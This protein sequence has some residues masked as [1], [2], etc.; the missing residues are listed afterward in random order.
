MSSPCPAIPAVWFNPDQEYITQKYFNEIAYR[1]R[2][3]YWNGGQN[4][5]LVIEDIR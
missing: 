3:N 5:Q 4:I 1:L 2:K